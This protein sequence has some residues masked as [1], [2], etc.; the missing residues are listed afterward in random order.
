MKSESRSDHGKLTFGEYAMLVGVL[1]IG[2]AFALL[3]HRALTEA[4][5]QAIERRT[6]AVTNEVAGLVKRNADAAAMTVRSLG[7]MYH[8]RG[9][10][11]H[12]E[13]ERFATTVLSSNTTTVQRLQWWPRIL[14]Q[15]D[16]RYEQ[17]LR[18]EIP[19]FQLHE[20][21]GAEGAGYGRQRLVFYPQLYAVPRA[22][23]EPGRA[24]EIAAVREISTVS[25]NPGA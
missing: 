15:D 21:D 13:F 8:L 22:V 5:R 18:E 2:I 4:T 6:E 11:G 9:G 14:T 3:L 19:E 10:I 7:W 24:R 12:Q 20:E 25:G 16:Q 23:A 1:L 17:T